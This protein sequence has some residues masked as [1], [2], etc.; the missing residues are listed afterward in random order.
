LRIGVFVFG[1][2]FLYDP[3]F[4]PD[5][6][7]RGGRFRLRYRFSGFG[8]PSATAVAV[9][10]AVPVKPG[11]ADGRSVPA[12]AAPTEP[13]EPEQKPEGQHGGGPQRERDPC[14]HV[15]LP[16]EKEKGPV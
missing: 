11:P 15:K 14:M 12:A 4:P 8:A 16:F 7:S 9:T 1:F 6:S 3:I 10:V 5:L 2:H 13:A